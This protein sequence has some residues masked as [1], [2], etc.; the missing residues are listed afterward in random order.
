MYAVV[1]KYMGA[2]A[3]IDAMASRSS[4]VEDL[5]GGV[6]GFLAYHA[7]RMSDGMITVTVC[8]DRAGTEESVRRAAEW[9][10]QNVTGVTMSPPEVT[11]GEV[12][13]DFFGSAYPTMA[14]PQGG[15][16]A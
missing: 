15:V 3:L 11:E 9:V 8:D 12:F 5:I 14:H 2:S 4:E 1:R 6:P 7:I 16:V 13:I 10:S